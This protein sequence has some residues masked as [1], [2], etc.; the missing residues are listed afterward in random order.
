MRF[1]FSTRLAPAIDVSERLSVGIANAEALGG[2]F[3]RPRWREAWAKLMA[4]ASSAGR[5]LAGAF[6]GWPL[7]GDALWCSSHQRGFM[8]LPQHFPSLRSGKRRCK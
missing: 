5:G 2:F 7:P 6:S 4:G 3:D 1:L 8:P